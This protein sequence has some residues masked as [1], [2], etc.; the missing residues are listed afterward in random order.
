ME[1]HLEDSVLSKLPDNYRDIVK[2]SIISEENDMSTQSS[3]QITKKKISCVPLEICAC[4]NY[5][6]YSDDLRVAL[7]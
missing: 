4:L 7:V 1:R 6:S 3:L 5:C 2:Q